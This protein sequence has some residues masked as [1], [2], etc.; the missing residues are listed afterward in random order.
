MSLNGALF[1]S[2]SVYENVGFRLFEQG[3]RGRNEE[4]VGGCL[5]RQFEQTI[6]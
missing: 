1:D 3:W 5:L 4:A 6:S 2:L